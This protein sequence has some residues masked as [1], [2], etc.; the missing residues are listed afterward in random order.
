MASRGHEGTGRSVQPLE[1]G[2]GHPPNQMEDLASRESPARV[3]ADLAGRQLD[4]RGRETRRGRREV[5]LGCI[6]LCARCRPKQAVASPAGNTCRTLDPG[7]TCE[8]EGKADE[9][10]VVRGGC[11]P[12]GY[13]TAQRDAGRL[14]ADPRPFHGWV[15]KRNRYPR[16]RRTHVPPRYRFVFRAHVPWHSSTFAVY[17]QGRRQASLMRR[18]PTELPRPVH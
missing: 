5:L 8:S 3:V 18:D 10:G 17:I 6:A 2:R 11:D 16:P 1:R 9:D 4:A 14:S 13:T 15:A 7:R 12:A